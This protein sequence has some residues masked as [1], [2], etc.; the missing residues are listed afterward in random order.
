MQFKKVFIRLGNL[1]DCVF[2]H[3]QNEIL[4]FIKI[5]QD[6]SIVKIR[7]ARQRMKCVVLISCKNKMEQLEHHVEFIQELNIPI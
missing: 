6:E 4:N 3:K 5:E 1:L 7:C 2:T